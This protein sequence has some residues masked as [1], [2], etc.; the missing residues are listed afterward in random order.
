MRV[1]PFG[2][3]LAAGALASAGQP[4]AGLGLFIAALGVAF[5]IMRR[6]FKP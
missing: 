5:E 4:I 2:L 3:A 6:E 1:I